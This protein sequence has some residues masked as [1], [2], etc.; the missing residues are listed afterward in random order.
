MR[1]RVAGARSLAMQPKPLLMDEPSS[2]PD[3]LTRAALQDKLERIWGERRS[4]VILATND[5]DEA[6]LLADPT[7][8]MTPGPG[9]VLGPAIE[10]GLPRPREGRHMSLTPYPEA[11]QEIVDFL[12]S[13]QPRGIWRYG[14]LTKFVT[15]VST[16]ALTAEAMIPTSPV[17]SMPLGRA[18]PKISVVPTCAPSPLPGSWSIACSNT[19]PVTPTLFSG[20]GH[21]HGHAIPCILPDPYDEG[22]AL[23]RGE[24]AGLVHRGQHA[25]QHVFSPAAGGE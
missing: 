6:I 17:T 20:D 1:Q 21:V 19:L 14:F 8:P 7:Y 2:A 5:V 23:Q 11:R 15:I 12:R 16:T 13:C 3:A 4:T 9:A 18:P 25:P 10:V 24:L 22:H